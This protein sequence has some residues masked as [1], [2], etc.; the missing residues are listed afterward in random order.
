MLYGERA[1]PYFM[2]DVEQIARLKK[3]QRILRD[4]SVDLSIIGLNDTLAALGET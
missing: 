4:A 1:V 3:T 2:P